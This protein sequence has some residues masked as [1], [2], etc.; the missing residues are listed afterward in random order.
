MSSPRTAS[1]ISTPSSTSRS[2]SFARARCGTSGAR[3]SGCRRPSTSG[4]YL[5]YLALER[6]DQHIRQRGREVLEMVKAE[7]RLAIVLLA[8]PYHNDPGLSHEIPAEFQKL[9]YPVLAQDS[10]PLDEDISE[11]VFGEDVW[12]GDVEHPL[13]IRDVWKNS[14]PRTPIAR[15]GP[16][17]SRL[18]TR[19]WWR[20]RCPTSSADMTP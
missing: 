20:S 6:F 2:G 19:I 9:G 18:A 12:R 1:P 11:E 17:S 7:E 16:P 5:V 13:D 15:C 3:S 10:L 4:R 14:T 8:R